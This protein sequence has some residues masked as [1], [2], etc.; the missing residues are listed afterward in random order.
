M[1][2]LP[3]HAVIMEKNYHNK[4]PSCVRWKFQDF[5]RVVTKLHTKTG[6]YCST[7]YIL[8]CTV[9]QNQL[10]VLHI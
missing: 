10:S 4:N 8:H 9:V 3:H 2:F 6:S 5:Q 7:G 1:Q